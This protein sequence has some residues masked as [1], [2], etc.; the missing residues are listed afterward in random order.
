MNI[1]DWWCIPLRNMQILLSKITG[2]EIQS[3]TN[4]IDFI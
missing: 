1:V 3:L 4:K 2:I